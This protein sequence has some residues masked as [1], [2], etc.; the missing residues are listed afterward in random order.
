MN[1]IAFFFTTVELCCSSS[2]RPFF[3][4]V[5]FHIPFESESRAKQ[6]GVYRFWI[7]W[8]TAE[9]WPFV[10]VL[11]WKW[12]RKVS[13]FTFNG[14]SCQD[15]FLRGAEKWYHFIWNFT[16]SNVVVESF[17]YH[18]NVIYSLGGRDTGTHTH[19]NVA[20]KSNFKKPCER[21]V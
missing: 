7:G 11:L 17:W 20:D 4:H 10:C 9:L 14:S 1:T 6:N 2:G 19:T 3:S 12:Q 18:V 13:F 21:L 8:T 15:S 16:V 5:I